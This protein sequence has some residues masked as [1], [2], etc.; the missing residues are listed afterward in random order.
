MTRFSPFFIAFM[1]ALLFVG[2]M[3]SL[4]V[5]LFMAD[6]VDHLAEPPH[7][8]AKMSEG[9]HPR[10]RVNG[11]SAVIVGDAETAFRTEQKLTMEID[12]KI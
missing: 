4:V 3:L 10:F 6:H 9:Y 11:M 12:K 2:S 5:F 7:T 1:N 8:T